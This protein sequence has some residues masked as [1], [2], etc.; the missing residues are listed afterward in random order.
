MCVV[1]NRSQ[2]DA[3]VS[4]ALSYEVPQEGLVVDVRLEF[5]DGRRLT[6]E[7]CKEEKWDFEDCTDLEL[8]PQQFAVVKELFDELLDGRRQQVVTY[9]GFDDGA[10][11]LRWTIN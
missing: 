7:F 1:K 9:T 3:A 11:M 4:L 10:R 2:M 8:T 6:A 5:S